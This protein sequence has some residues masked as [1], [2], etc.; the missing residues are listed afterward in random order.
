MSSKEII[1]KSEIFIFGVMIAFFFSAHLFIPTIP[2]K[3]VYD[4]YNLENFTDTIKIKFSFNETIRIFV[5]DNISILFFNNTCQTDSC[6]IIVS[7]KNVTLYV[8][9][10]VR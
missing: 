8:L 9:R 5:V 4:V 2:L 7:Q 1:H 6:E 3:R 10:E